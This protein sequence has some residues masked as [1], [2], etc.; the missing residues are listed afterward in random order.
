MLKLMNY[1]VNKTPET[2]FQSA[3]LNQKFYLIPTLKNKKFKF[4]LSI[5]KSLSLLTFT[6]L[7][8]TIETLE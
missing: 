2:H 6:C 8:S 7:K 3:L 4:H 5:R 1:P